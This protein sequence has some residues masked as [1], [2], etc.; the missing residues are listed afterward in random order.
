MHP[1]FHNRYVRF[2]GIGVLASIVLLTVLFLIN[3]TTQSTGLTSERSLNQLPSVSTPGASTESSIAADTV[4]RAP[5]PTPSD[6]TGDLERYELTNYAVSAR[7]KEFDTLCDTL[8]IFK[9]RDDID[10]RSLTRSTN[11]CAGNFFVTESQVEGVLATLQQVSGVEVSRTTQSVT[12]HRERLQSQADIVRQ[13]LRS[14][15]HS[16]VIAETEFD[17]IA[18]FARENN[19]AATLSEAIREK[20]SLVKTLTQEKISLNQRL[21]SLLQQS[22]ELEAR[23]DVVEFN[24]QVTRSY[25][26]DRNETAREWERAWAALDE[27]FTDT[28]IGLT[29]TFGI[30]VLWALRLALYALVGLIVL[31]FLWKGG[32]LIWRKL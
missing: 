3:L 4:Y 20:L 13:R 32:R 14:V 21:D 31:R 18:T 12:R 30:V 7:T 19:D 17:T 9:Q 15:N 25:P 16:L 2:A 22:A 11:R 10:F 6:Y 27:T 28:L 8:E 29:A 26:L 24:V 5:Q 23:L 1:L